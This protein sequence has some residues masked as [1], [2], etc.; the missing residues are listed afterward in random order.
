LAPVQLDD[1]AIAEAEAQAA[2][3]DGRGSDR[4][5]DREWATALLRQ[6]MV[7]LEQESRLAGKNALFRELRSY[8]TNNAQDAAP[9]EELAA[10]LARPAVTLRSDV[11]RLRARYRMILREEVRG[12]VADPKDV[13]E[14]LQYLRQ[15]LAA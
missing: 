4:E 2:R 3:S 7:R 6:V 5:Y 15:A 1:A 8:L 11:A 10:R 13:D 14:E 9:Y 12:T